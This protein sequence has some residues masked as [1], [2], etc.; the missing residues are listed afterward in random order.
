M[1]LLLSIFV[2]CVIKQQLTG[3]QGIGLASQAH[4]L[5]LLAKYGT[6]NYP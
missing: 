3:G 5:G 1:L 2:M 6:E 4:K